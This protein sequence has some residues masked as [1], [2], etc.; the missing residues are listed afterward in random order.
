MN[1]NKPLFYRIAYDITN[2]SHE[3]YNIGTL[4][5]KKLHLILKQYFEPDTQYHEIP[6]NG[7]IADIL[8]DNAITE[9]ETSGFSGLNPKLEAYLPDYH[10]ALV[11]PIAAERYI[12][13]IDG[14]TGNISPKRR[15]PKK[16]NIYDALYECIR[17]KKYLGNPNLT[18]VVVFLEIH[19]YRMLDG[20]S[21]DRKKG[22]HRYERIPTDILE[23]IEFTDK[24]SYSKWIP[25]ECQNNFTISAFAKNAGITNDT[26][27]AVVKVMESVGVLQFNGKNGRQYLY[28]RTEN[29]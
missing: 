13:W 14:D 26:A 15:S 16:K 4:K 22:S 9:I 8:R 12:S 10:V 6:C 23:I 7:F 20:W 18:V 24:E 2:A 19:E 27:Q 5:E 21:Y 1:I 25:D 11:L 29:L 28:S 3:R 17:I